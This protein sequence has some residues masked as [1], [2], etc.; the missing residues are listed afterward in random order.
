[1]AKLLFYTVPVKLK[2]GEKPC[3]RFIVKHNGRIG[4][5]SFKKRLAKRC[6]YSQNVVACVMDACGDQMGEE[7]A[8]GN[9][10]DIGWLHAFNVCHGSAK[11]S[12]EPWN[13]KKNR[14]A[15][16]FFAKGVLSEC[17][18]GAEMENVTNG[19]SVSIKRV[20]DTV[21]G[22]DNTISGTA[23]VLARATGA[24]LEVNPESPDE[25][26]WLED[27]NG[28]VAAVATVTESTN[29]EVSFRFATLPPDGSYT[30][31][32]ASRNNMGEEFGVAMARKKVTVCA[33][34]GE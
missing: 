25:G 4:E 29:I 16:A 18:K 11:S 3:Y 2:S 33:V 30:L 13:S 17:L 1:M 9:R 10:V 28:V 31:V 15:A 14:I 27:Q 12:R 23:N 21:A 5:K 6:G 32:I 24:G 22:I 8:N 20:W 34:A 26:I 19:P 7:L